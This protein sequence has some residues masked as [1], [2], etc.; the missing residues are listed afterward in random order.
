MVISPFNCAGRSNKSLV[1]P[2]DSSTSSS[3]D[4]ICSSSDWSNSG[5]CEESGSIGK[6][7]FCSEFGSAS[8][9]SDISLLLPTPMFSST[10]LFTFKV[11]ESLE[12]FESAN[13]VA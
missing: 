8:L 3:N 9:S 13:T 6:S 10:F 11:V 7:A 2:S 4:G 12:R 1:S 5:V